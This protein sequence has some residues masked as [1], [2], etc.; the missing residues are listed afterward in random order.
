LEE[1]LK[2]DPNHAEAWVK[3]GSALERLRQDEGA[4]R[5]YDRAI[6]L[7]SA[8]TLAYLLKGGVCNR[9]KRF[10]EAVTCYEEALKVE[11]AGRRNPSLARA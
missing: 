9:L 11:E 2:L 4:V 6:E 5:C 10:D 8:L 3:K 7:N 1:I